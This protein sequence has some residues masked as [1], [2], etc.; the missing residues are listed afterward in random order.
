MSEGNV[1]LFW[2]GVEAFNGD[3]PA[4]LDPLITEDFEFVSYLAT[5]IEDTVYRGADGLRKYLEDQQAA[6]KDLHLRIDEVRDLGDRVLAFGEI[7]G[8]G[9][10]SGLEVKV[11]LTWIVDFRDGRMSRNRTYP[12]RDAALREAGLA[13]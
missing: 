3:D 11:P 9:R 4:A 8:E 10:A 13:E 2:R 6:W 1:E 5:M 12:D 7:Q